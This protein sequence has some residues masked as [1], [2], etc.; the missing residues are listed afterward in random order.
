MALVRGNRDLWKA[1]RYVDFIYIPIL[2]GLSLLLLRRARLRFSKRKVIYSLHDLEWM[3]SRK[4]RV[5]A[6]WASD[7]VH[8]TQCSLDIAITSNPYLARK[9]N[10]VIAPAVDISNRTSEARLNVPAIASR[11][12][13]FVGQVAKH[14]GIEVLLEAFRRI[15]PEF[16]DV[17]LDIAGGA[18]W[19]YSDDFQQV[20]DATALN[21]R[22]RQWGYVK[23]VEPLLRSCYVY[24]DPLCHPC[25]TDPLGEAQWR[26]CLPELRSFVFAAALSPKLLNTI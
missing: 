21:G 14:K 11:R 12:I 6:S 9:R 13:L 19:Q 15:A 26:R 20:L 25:S 3:P 10:H 5:A 2:T 16:P 7:F 4:L 8:L 24:V 17:T 1:A 22:I 18:D 23:D